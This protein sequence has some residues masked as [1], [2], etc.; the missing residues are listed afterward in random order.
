MPDEPQ[1]PAFRRVLDQ[2]SWTGS[3]MTI[4]R[5]D[6]QVPPA[7]PGWYG[8]IS[9][10]GGGPRSGVAAIGRRI[11]CWP[12]PGPCR[13]STRKPQ[14]WI[15]PPRNGMGELMPFDLDPETDPSI[16]TAA[17]RRCWPHVAGERLA[18]VS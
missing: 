10:A 18:T 11:R 16:G 5:C 1:H 6:F 8:I 9:A 17:R 3:R 4:D 13:I 7:K 12:A 2:F 14:R 15:G